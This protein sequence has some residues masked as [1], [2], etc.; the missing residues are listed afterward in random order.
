MRTPLLGLV[1]I[2]VMVSLTVAQTISGMKSSK[3]L[4][5]VGWKFA[6]GMNGMI[7]NRKIRK[8]KIARKKENEIA[9]ALVAI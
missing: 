2:S 1:M 9:E 7:E 6:M 5:R 8:G 4:R 3:R